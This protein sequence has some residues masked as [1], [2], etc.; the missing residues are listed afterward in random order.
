MDR[1]R[2]RIFADTVYR[3]LAGAMTIGMA[4]LGVRTGLFAT[5]AGKGAMTVADVVGASGLDARYVE[6]WLKGMTA[7]GYL[8]HDAVADRFT[9]PE[10]HAYLVA[11]EGTDHFMGGLFLAAPAMLRTAPNV[12]RAFRDGGGV[13]D[14]EFGPDIVEALDMINAGQYENRFTGFWLNKLPEV[15]QRLEQGGRALDVG[16]GVGRVGGAIA[17]AFP[18]CEVVGLDPDPGSIARA[19]GLG[20]CRAYPLRRRGHVDLRWRRWLRSDY[21][22]RLCA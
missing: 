7:A 1:D 20:R 17:H 11:S 6:E 9:L 13:P 21:R 12:A 14:E 3:D 18:K 22:L 19:S 2:I 5:L 10:E 8:E 16:C 15:T 4:Y